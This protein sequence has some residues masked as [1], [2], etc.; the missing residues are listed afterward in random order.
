M[1]D[2][3]LTQVNGRWELYLP[4]Y[5]AER[6]EWR[7]GWEVERLDSMHA[8]IREGDVVYDVGTEEG[9]LSGLY[10]L[11][12]A[13]L[14]FAEPNDFVWPNVK[15]IWEANDFPHPVG[16][17]HG[18]LSNRYDFHQ[19]IDVHGWP[20][21]ASLPMVRAH[22]FSSLAEHLEQ[23]EL[24]S[25]KHKDTMKLD[26]LAG[27]VGRAP[28]HITI[29]VEGAEMLVLEGAQ[30]TLERYRP[31]VWVSVHDEMIRYDYNYRSESVHQYM[32]ERRYRMQFLA[33]DHENHWVYWP[34]EREVVL[35]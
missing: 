2:M 10:A 4:D 25:A 6:A 18:F 21:A 32:A 33:S 26:T 9:D 22:G 20:W 5:R 19:P 7:T 34:E 12:G 17:Y 14:V 29:D 35:L 11:W 3:V 16:W 13:M 8:N 1:A 27:L 24:G 31:L 30:G 28:Q 15:A 23:K